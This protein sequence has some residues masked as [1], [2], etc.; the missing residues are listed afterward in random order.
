MASTATTLE[1]T[2]LTA[3]IGSQ[4]RVDKQV[5]LSGAASREI[6]ALLVARG[7]VMMRDIDLTDEE[8]RRLAGTL[9]EV[10]LGT[11]KKEGEDGLMKVT[12]D[13]KVNPEYAK[14]FFGSLMWHMDGHYEEVPPFATVVRPRVL[15]PESHTDFAN[16][17]AAYEDL[18]DEDK[19]LVE[20][21]TVVHTMQS[22]LFP[23]KPDCTVEEFALWAS[24]PERAHPLVWHH[25]SG[26]KSLILSTSGAW[27]PGL[28][29][30][31]SAELLQRLMRHAT[32]P[33]YVYR[34]TWRPN[35]LL[36]WDNT[37]TMHRARPH[38]PA[39]ARVLARFTLNGEEPIR[40]A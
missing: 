26:R 32:Q 6:R 39:H 28:H 13:E 34:H 36:L 33:R 20:G 9:G 1:V 14:F 31:E 21:L 25:R 16:T 3:R 8:H 19:A 10:R 17:Y 2:D 37:G 11:F 5:L 35:D 18:S 15:P 4:F 12:Q 30:V 40:A 38:D 23:A 27:I 29:K 24:Y 22:A 7:V